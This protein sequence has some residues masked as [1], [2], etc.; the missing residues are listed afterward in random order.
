MHDSPEWQEALDTNGWTDFLQTGDEYETFL[1]EEN[2]R[3]E[4]VLGEMGLAG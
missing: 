2:Q 3:V 1:E 4:E